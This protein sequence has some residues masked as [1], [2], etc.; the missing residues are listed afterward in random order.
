MTSTSEAA[1]N[2]VLAAKVYETISSAIHK[3]HDA[4]QNASDAAQLARDEVT[5]EWD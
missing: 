2:P 4:A 5:I 1:A 3:A